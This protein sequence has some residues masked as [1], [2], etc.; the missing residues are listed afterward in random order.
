MSV[1]GSAGI[2]SSASLDGFDDGPTLNPSRYKGAA[3]M[4]SE[5]VTPFRRGVTPYL[6]LPTRRHLLVRR[7]DFVG[8]RHPLRHRQHALRYPRVREAP[9]LPPPRRRPAA[10]EHGRRRRQHRVHERV[11]AVVG[12]EVPAEDAPEVQGGPTQD[13]PLSL[14]A[15][16]SARAD[17]AGFSSGPSAEGFP[18]ARPITSRYRPAMR[19]VGRH[20]LLAVWVIRSDLFL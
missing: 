18:T 19:S 14:L 1:F 2:S 11:A 5:G 6:I 10:P 7:L 20:R 9:Y 15:S 13:E 3:L 4:T 12:G 16:L 17:R 8:F